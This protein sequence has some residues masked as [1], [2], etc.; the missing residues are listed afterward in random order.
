MSKA[1]RVGVAITEPLEYGLLAA[2]SIRHPSSWSPSCLAARRL[3]RS[4]SALKDRL[5]SFLYER[6]VR[7]L[8]KRVAG[9]SE[10][11]GMP[12]HRMV[13]LWTNYRFGYQRH[14]FQKPDRHRSRRSGMA[15][16]RPERSVHDLRKTNWRSQDA[17][18]DPF[19]PAG[20]VKASAD[21][22]TDTS[23]RPTGRRS[24]SP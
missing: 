12:E 16:D 10:K 17:G 5:E 19:R 11:P 15:P 9:V 6:A 23:Q 20:M 14:H 22:P 13:I 21:G 24:E 8:R 4:W 1:V 7:F 18:S 2:H 3:P